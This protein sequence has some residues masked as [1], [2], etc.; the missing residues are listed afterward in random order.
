MRC[1][2]RYGVRYSAEGFEL[3]FVRGLNSGGQA[4]EARFFHHD[5]SVKIDRPGI[6]LGGYLAVIGQNIIIFYRLQYIAEP[7]CADIS[8]R[9][10]AEI[11]AFY[12]FIR[13][14]RFYPAY[15]LGNVCVRTRQ[16]GR[17]AEI[18]VAAFR[19]AIRDMDI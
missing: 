18:A 7:L 2:V 6:C 4:V 16:I 19:S 15:K 14:I 11:Y 17:R 12:G 1:A 3:V 10:A 5:K 13:F 8:R 9:A